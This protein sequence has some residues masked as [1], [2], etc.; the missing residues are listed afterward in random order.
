MRSW[1]WQVRTTALIVAMIPP[2][3]GIVATI[4]PQQ[5]RDGFHF[6]RWESLSSFVF[7]TMFLTIPLSYVFISLPALI[8]GGIYCAV[9]TRMPRL[10]DSTVRRCA[11]A[12]VVGASVG[13]LSSYFILGTGAFFYGP[14][15]GVA[16][17][18]FATR[19]PAKEVGAILTGD[20]SESG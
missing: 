7:T 11:L 10:R 5:Y 9:L 3:I 16:A 2:V 4:A 13:A 18:V 1:R 8:G 14:I 6:P 17:L 12:F 20:S 19:W 15:G